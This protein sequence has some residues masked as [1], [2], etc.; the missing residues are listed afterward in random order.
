MKFKELSKEKVNV[1]E[2]EI[3][4]RWKKED[5]LNKTIENREGCKNFV[6]YDGPATAN[7]HPGL[8]HMIAK[9]LKDSICLCNAEINC[10]EILIELNNSLYILIKALFLFNSGTLSFI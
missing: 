5:I 1:V 4:E 3:L 6:F 10:L 2:E 7:G 9:F 8:H